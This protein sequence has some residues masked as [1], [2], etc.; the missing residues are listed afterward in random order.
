MMELFNI[1]N[2][3][4]ENNNNIIVKKDEDEISLLNKNN[5]REIKIRQ[6]EYEASDTSD[7]FIQYTMHF[8]YNHWYS[9][10]INEIFELVQY[11][12]NDEE[13]VVQFFKDNKKSFG[14]GMSIE[15]YN[16]LSLNFLSEYY[17][18]SDEYILERDIEVVSWS[19]KYDI[20]RKPTKEL[21]K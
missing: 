13:L 14:S 6:D 21:K 3:H 2:K 19:G 4:F 20:P 11:I 5:K 12:V 17:G 10:N 9:N 7:R 16:R 8:S 1:I 18:Y 15:D